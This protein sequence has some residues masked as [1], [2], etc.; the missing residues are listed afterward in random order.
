MTYDSFREPL[1]WPAPARNL[2]L[3]WDLIAIAR[4]VLAARDGLDPAAA[5]L[6]IPPG[7]RPRPGA[8]PVSELTRTVVN[9]LKGEGDS[10]AALP[11]LGPKA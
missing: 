8:L 6:I 10:T 11:A 1:D 7:V 4:R 3:R 9:F 5:A 2:R